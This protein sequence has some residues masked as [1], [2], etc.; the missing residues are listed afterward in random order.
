[1]FGNRQKFTE[2][3]LDE[4]NILAM[5][6][7]TRSDDEALLGS[8][9]VHDEFLE[10]SSIQVVDV[11]M[12]SKSG[13]A[14]CLVTIRSSEQGLLCFSEGIVL[15]KV[16][17]QVMGLV[18]LRTSNICSKDRTGL[19]SEVDHHL[20]H[21]DGVILDAVA[22][23]VGALL[24]VIHLHGTTGHLNHAIVDGLIGVLQGL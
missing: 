7:D 8:D 24:I 9:V 20:E 12:K 2:S 10:N 4:V 11:S 22:S 16:F 15:S 17:V 14:E 19:K 21:I 6:S 18:V 23:E 3:L 1:V 5:V 13:H